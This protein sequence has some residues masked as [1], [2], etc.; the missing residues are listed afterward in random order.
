ME[1]YKNYLAA[2]VLSEDRVVCKVL[3]CMNLRLNTTRSPIAFSVELSK[4]M[5]TLQRSRYALFY[6]LFMA[7]GSRM[8]YEFHQQ[9]NAKK[10]GTIHATY[11]ISGTKL[12]EISVRA[13]HKDGED[14]YMQSSPFMSSSLPQPSEETGETSVLSISLVREEDLESMNMHFLHTGTTAQGNLQV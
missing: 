4:S 9:Q 5:L 3:A 14:E 13:G 11:L 6:Y 2:N 1:D 10:P 12:K 8:L 7:N